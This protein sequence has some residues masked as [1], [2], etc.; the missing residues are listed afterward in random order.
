MAQSLPRE[1]ARLH[2]RYLKALHTKAGLR[3]LPSETDDEFLA[4]LSRRAP[5]HA[6]LAAAFVEAWRRLRFA[7]EPAARA[8]VEARLHTLER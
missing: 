6:A 1:L 3:M 4:R 2:N 7:G 8:D 5:D